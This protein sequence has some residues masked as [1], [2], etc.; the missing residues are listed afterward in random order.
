L[1]KE[2]VGKYS[3]N[4]RRKSSIE[5]EKRGEREEGKILGREKK[6]TR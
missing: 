6:L 1:W 5:G 2:D 4:F 3:G